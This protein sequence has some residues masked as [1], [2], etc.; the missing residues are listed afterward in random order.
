MGCAP[1]D[2]R[3]ILS[4]KKYA[5]P[6][7]RIANTSAIVMPPRP[8]NACPRNKRSS[9]SAVNRNAVL[10]VFM[11]FPRRPLGGARLCGFP[12]K[13]HL[14]VLC[15]R[16]DNN[17]ITRMNLAIEDLQRQRVLDQPLN[18]PFHRTRTIRRVE[19]F[20][21]EQRLRSLREMQ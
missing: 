7:M 17:F 18:R 11:F 12:R 13:C 19:A 9:V 14:C 16:L 6:F 2:M 8:P 21:E 1:L 15:V 3:A 4:E 10:K 5:V 20:S